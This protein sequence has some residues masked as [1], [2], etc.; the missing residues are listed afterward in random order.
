MRVLPLSSPQRALAR[1]RCTVAP[2]RR[3]TWCL[4]GLFTSILVAA[5]FA[6]D[7]EPLALGERPSLRA[8]VTSLAINLDGR[9]TEP[10]WQAAADSIAD[11]T[12]VEPDEGEPPT[13]PTIVKVLSDGTGI[14]VGVRCI[15]LEPDAIVS[16][17][18]A[19]DPE[20]AE[21]DHVVIVL[22]TFLDGRSGYAFAVNPSGARFDGLV[23]GAEDEVNADWDAIWEA[24]TARTAEGWS[25]EIRIPIKSL[26][27]KRGATTWGFNVQRVVPRSQEIARWSSPDLDYFVHQTSRAGLLTDL[28]AFELGIG[29]TI[30]PAFVARARTPGAHQK[31][32]VR[33]EWSLDAIQRLGPNVNAA[34]TVNTDFAETEVDV[35]RS[36]V[37][38]FELFF[39]E[40]RSFFLE[41][42][43]LFEFGLGL[44]EENLLPF[45]S[46]R[47]GLFGPEED[48][49]V[50]VPIQVG[51]KLAGRIGN[52]N[53][54]GL[55][56]NT[57]ETFRPAQTVDDFTVNLPQTT[58]GAVRVSQNV[59][60]ES[61]VGMLATVGD[62][63]GLDD[64]W[65]AG[66]D[67]T[68]QTSSFRGERNLLAGVWGMMNDRVDLRGDKGAWGARVEYPNDRLD[69]NLTTIRIG[70]GFDP[71]LGFVPRNNIQIWDFG[72][73]FKPRPRLP[74]LR[75]TFYEAS[76][77]LFMKRDHSAWESYD[78]TLMPFDWLLES[79]DR[80][81]FGATPEGDRPPEA[82]EVSGDI[83]IPAGSYEWVR[84]FAGAR[85]AE[86]R[87]VSGELRWEFGD[88]YN[89]DL[90]A[91]LARLTVKPSALF[92]VELTGERNTG[93]AQALPDDFEGEGPV[94]LSERTFKEQ[95]Y[96]VR[97]LLNVSPD[98]QF[99]SLTQY[100]TDSRELGTNNHLRWTFAPA[101]DLFV[102]Y[103]HNLVRRVR[104]A[105]NRWVF[106]GNEIPVKIQY[107]FRF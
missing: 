55:I 18:K 34:L 37:T 57:D 92:S 103:N 33:G 43:D 105:G 38:R 12:M 60:E 99:S 27:F 72:G 53:I 76:G 24:A 65:A 10:A 30:R 31:T 15:D 106:T 101:G 104:R 87:R 39:P 46:R 13:A 73:E 102:V 6:E 48:D 42:S 54:V 95:V 85:A 44:D 32:R 81:D 93:K 51:G 45:H 47:I 82:F 29:L 22:D 11:L 35:R 84:F 77:T 89:G 28:P 25:A 5:A 70:D 7:E 40:K 41:G 79:G 50:E 68:F 14:I 69:L 1:S 80:F 52:T 21:E 107:A 16:F 58:M 23:S 63:R 91:L 26:S 71:S 100:D 88:Y 36:N 96:G 49:Q 56:A 83:D 61:T 98:L 64:A 97:A 59:L 8:T 66:V 2:S 4:A 62:Q 90:Y 17:S 20:L 74:W 94:A 78:A 75:R 19:R 86:K 9:L 3:R 67:F